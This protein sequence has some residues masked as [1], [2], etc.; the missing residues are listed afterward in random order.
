MMSVVEW[1]KAQGLAL[2]GPVPPCL[3]PECKAR[4]K[5]L[6]PWMTLKPKLAKRLRKVFPWW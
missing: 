2:P 3:R 4:M 5:A 1:A 6:I